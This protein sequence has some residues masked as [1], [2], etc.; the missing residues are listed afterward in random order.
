MQSRSSAYYIFPKK[1]IEPNW[2]EKRVRVNSGCTHLIRTNINAEIFIDPKG[3]K[4]TIELLF[5]AVQGQ[6]PYG[7]WLKRLTRG[8]K[9]PRGKCGKFFIENAHL[10]NNY[11][12][13]NQI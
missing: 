11:Q 9:A 1:E 13:G 6:K 5:F 2:V 4:E 3:D 10:K 7:E 12:Q 8:E